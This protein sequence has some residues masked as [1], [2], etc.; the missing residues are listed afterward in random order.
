MQSHSPVPHVETSVL[1]KVTS[2]EI[3]AKTAKRENTHLCSSNYRAVFSSEMHTKLAGI[4]IEP[5]Y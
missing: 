5:E 2:R 4:K 1:V 3:I